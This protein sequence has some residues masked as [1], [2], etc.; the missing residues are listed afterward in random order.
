LTV[1]VIYEAHEI[2]YMTKF[3]NQTSRQWCVRFRTNI[4]SANVTCV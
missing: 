4:R 3:I 1:S 2:I